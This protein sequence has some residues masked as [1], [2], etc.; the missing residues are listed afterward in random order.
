MFKTLR[1]RIV[2][3]TGFYLF[4][5][6]AILFIVFIKFA[7]LGVSADGSLGMGLVKAAG[8]S[9]LCWLVGVAAVAWNI[10]RGLKPLEEVSAA[11]ERIKR[12]G[13]KERI[14]P[15]RM[16][17]IGQAEQALDGLVGVLDKSID[18][19]QERSMETAKSINQL[20]TDLLTAEQAL[21]ELV[22]A[23]GE[24]AQRFER[25]IENTRQAT[26]AIN[27][28]A[29]GAEDIARSAS[30]A[31]GNSSATN[32]RAL[33]AN[34]KIKTIDQNIHE[35]TQAA[36]E[37]VGTVDAMKHSSDKIGEILNL[38]VSI[39]DETNLLA[40]NAAIEAARA[41]EHGRGFAVV[42]DEIRHL[43]ENTKDSTRSISGLVREIT[44][45]TDT[46]VSAINNIDQ[47]IT[48]SGALIEEMLTGIQEITRSMTSINSEIQTVAAGTQ[49]QTAASQQISASML[50]IEHTGFSTLEALG[51]VRQRIDDLTVFVQKTK[52]AMAETN[53][54][55]QHWSYYELRANMAQRRAEHEKWVANLRNRNQVQVDPTRCNFGQFYYAYEP[56]DPLVLKVY[57]EFEEPHRRLHQGG[58]RVLELHQQGKV[59]ESEAAMA[60][61]ER[62]YQEMSRLFEAFYDV[63]EKRFASGIIMF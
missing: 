21:E 18:S 7:K 44:D 22:R 29:K 53:Q 20:S 5:M 24:F 16:K 34:Q 60:D 41:G 30:D 4:L 38:I 43:A 28:I 14:K 17:E 49:E 37:A 33:E 46:V 62:A 58:H 54:A 36:S 23:N 13:F 50:E 55:A 52:T 35:M 15:A 56:N 11:I 6:Q 2:F 19:M 1:G 59:A 51:E 45:S 48:R 61:V 12:E 8:L 27:E 31:A 42:A 10:S 39:A 63:M 40:L 47:A 32:E 57:R 26:T 3:L 9:V 25:V